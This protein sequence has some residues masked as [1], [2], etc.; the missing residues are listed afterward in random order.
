MAPWKERGL[1][2]FAPFAL[3]VALIQ[4]KGEP[5]ALP[6]S[7]ALIGAFLHW[8]HL[9]L[10]PRLEARFNRGEDGAGL[11][12]FPRPDTCT[13]EAQI[14]KHRSDYN[15]NAWYALAWFP[16]GGAFAAIA[17]VFLHRVRIREH[18]GYSR[19]E[20]VAE[21]AFHALVTVIAVGIGQWLITALYYGFLAVCDANPITCGVKL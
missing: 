21:I 20:A 13:S 4:F 12:F 18:L 3:A 11:L 2:L 14:L 15:S 19:H 10:L 9:W 6:L 16:F 5:L 17:A 1:K 8:W 7:W